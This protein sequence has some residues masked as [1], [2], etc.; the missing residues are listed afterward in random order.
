M[1]TGEPLFDLPAPQ[2]KAGLDC[3]LRILCHP[4][5]AG[6]AQTDAQ[7]GIQP[8]RLAVRATAQLVNLGG[9]PFAAVALT[10]ALHVPGEHLAAA[11]VAQRFLLLTFLADG[12]NP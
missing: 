2:R 10:A 9:S 6:R 1:S 3:G 8:A 11:L 7:L 5:V 4:P 12:T